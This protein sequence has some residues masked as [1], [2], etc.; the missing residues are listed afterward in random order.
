M[1]QTVGTHGASAG[2]DGPLTMQTVGTH[3]ASA[4]GDGPSMMQTVGTNSLVHAGGGIPP[5]DWIPPTIAELGT[6]NTPQYPR[7]KEGG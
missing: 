4:G 2:G 7:T 1:M 6:H 5:I 3:G